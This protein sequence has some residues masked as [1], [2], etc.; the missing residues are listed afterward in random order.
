MAQSPI[1]IPQFD[2]DGIREKDNVCCVCGSN[3]DPLHRY[4]SM[5]VTDFKLYSRRHPEVRKRGL[6]PFLSSLG[7]SVF[8]VFGHIFAYDLDHESKSEV[9]FCSRDCA[10]SWSE[11]NDTILFADGE[12]V[13]ISPHQQRLDQYARDND[14]IHHLMEIEDGE[15][16]RIRELEYR[17]ANEVSGLERISHLAHRAYAWGYEQMALE[18]TK[19]I[20]SHHTPEEILADPRSTSLLQRT[21]KFE[22]L[23]DL[24][25]QFEARQGI[26][27]LGSSGYSTWAYFLAFSPHHHEEAVQLSKT[28]VEL[29]HRDEKAFA[30]HVGILRATG[31][32]PNEVLSFVKKWKGELSQH[33]SLFHAGAAYARAGEYR[34]GLEY[35]RKAHRLCS[36]SATMRYLAESL[37][38]TGKHHEALSVCRRG[39]KCVEGGDKQTYRDSDGASIGV[40]EKAR[41]SKIAFRKIFLALEGRILLDIGESSTGV[42][43]LKR[44]I[45]INCNVDDPVLEGLEFLANGYKSRDS[46][47]KSIASKKEKINDLKDKISSLR[48]E[49]PS[50]RVE[51]NKVQEIEDT[52]VAV[53]KAEAPSIPELR[54]DAEKSVNEYYPYASTTATR[55]LTEAYYL[56]FVLDQTGTATGD[57]AAPMVHFAKALEHH[58]RDSFTAVG[59]DVDTSKS[60]GQ[61]LQILN[62]HANEIVEK[63]ELDYDTIRGYTDTIRKIKDEFRN[64]YIH[65]KS[66]NRRKIN[67]LFRIGENRNPF[68]S[69]AG[70]AI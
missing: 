67:E 12:T 70:V 18:A 28:A 31:S 34:T 59:L 43:I 53:S 38:R 60:L 8:L 48:E 57:W 4:D 24:Y 36:D 10:I 50:A 39:R 2:E 26:S 25:K 40:F 68:R 61:L 32:K 44:S 13:I 64:A 22:V 7:H 29:D 15:S 47:S 9:A 14:L 54:R 3:H 45:D 17:M 27:A 63:G 55:S 42:E 1:A 16:A 6:G 20:V 46:L 49:D 30:N 5:D 58:L 65:E 33:M 62:C 19:H 56:R 37:W 41:P 52:V 69:L 51:G 11:Q 23:N 21:E 66:M 35:L